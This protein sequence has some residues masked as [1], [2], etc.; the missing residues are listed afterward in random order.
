M[1]N[2]QCKGP[3]L[4]TDV[5]H[6]FWPSSSKIKAKS[7]LGLL[8]VAR[9]SEAFNVEATNY[10]GNPVRRTGEAYEGIL[11]TLSCKNNVIANEKIVTNMTLD[12]TTVTK[13]KTP[14]INSL[15]ESLQIVYSAMRAPS[16]LGITSLRG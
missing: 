7:I 8:W 16:Q 4:T 6:Q 1:G 3:Y 15:V 5:R 13:K 14:K 11:I 10:S 2:E 9:P 12:L